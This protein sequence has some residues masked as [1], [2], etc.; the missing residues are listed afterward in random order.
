MSD[1][2]GHL[3]GENPRDIRSTSSDIDLVV[4]N[5][6]DIANF[7]IICDPYKFTE[8]YQLCAKSK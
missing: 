6:I 7:D 3:V 8:L 1:K 5:Y 2:S 4:S